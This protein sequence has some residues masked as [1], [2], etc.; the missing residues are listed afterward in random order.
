LEV[1]NYFYNGY[2]HSVLFCVSGDFGILKAKV[3][4]SQRAAENNQEA[5]VILSMMDGSVK[6]A[7]YTCTAGY[8]NIS[9]VLLNVHPFFSLGEVCSHVAVLLFKIETAC[10]LGYTNPSQTSLPWI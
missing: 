9:V 10:R 5:W 2:V 6:T 3:N 7:H 4:P 8:V 1:Y